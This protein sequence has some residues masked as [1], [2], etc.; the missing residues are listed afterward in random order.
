MTARPPYLL[1]ALIGLAGAGGVALSAIAAHRVDSPALVSAALLLMIHAT[2]ALALIA[3][4]GRDA[5]PAAWHGVAVAM[6]L[7]AVLFAGAVTLNALT[8]QR[9]FA[10]AAPTGGSIMIAAWLVASVLA[11]VRLIRSA[12]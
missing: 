7:G 1:I 12:R 3:L 9:L 8:G 4:A 6:L 10:M 5:R 11:I 2:A